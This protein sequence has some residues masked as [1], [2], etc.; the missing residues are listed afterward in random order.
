M[1]GD[2]LDSISSRLEKLAA[3]L[4]GDLDQERAAELVR[5]ASELAARAGEEVDRALRSAA[6]AREA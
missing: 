3:E 5:E 2:D 1:A 4:E 6:E